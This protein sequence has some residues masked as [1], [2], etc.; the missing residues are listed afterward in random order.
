[1]LF[2]VIRKNSITKEGPPRREDR[3]K[4]S[5]DRLADWLAQAASI[6]SSKICW[7][8]FVFFVRV[9]LP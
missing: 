3:L 9:A 8:N 2:K 6:I 7:S 1:M 5:L 4:D